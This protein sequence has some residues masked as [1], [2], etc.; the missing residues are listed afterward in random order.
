[1]PQ[2][3]TLLVL[4]NAGRHSYQIS[5]LL[6]L[7]IEGNDRDGHPVTIE[8]RMLPGKHPGP[9]LMPLDVAPSAEVEM[10]IKLH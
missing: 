6:A 1:M 5:M 7:T 8:R 4:H 3:G 10:E 2:R 9:V